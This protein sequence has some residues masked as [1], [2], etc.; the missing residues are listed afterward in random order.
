[1]T[2]FWLVAIGGA[3]GSMARYGVGLLA[4]RWLGPDFPWGTLS[5]NIV[6]GVVMGL[7]FGLHADKKDLVLFAT[8]GVLGGF[9]TFSAFSLETVRMMMGGRPDM[10]ALY[11]AASVILA[12][13]GV[14]AGLML[15]RALQ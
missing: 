11:I 14:F 1:V 12:C 8:T 13:L 7:M 15:A 6:G 3:L 9:T 4:V 5:V 2:G 10:A